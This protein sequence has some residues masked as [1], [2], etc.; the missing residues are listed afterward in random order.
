LSLFKMSWMCVR[1]S[2][3]ETYDIH[4]FR[5]GTVLLTNARLTRPAG[6]PRVVVI[7]SACV[8]CCP[9]RDEDHLPRKEQYIDPGSEPKRS[10]DRGV[11]ADSVYS[12]T[13]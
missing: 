11:R 5:C 3:I 7:R 10:E 8:P 6:W 9:N 2:L 1:T 12:D 4:R 13:T